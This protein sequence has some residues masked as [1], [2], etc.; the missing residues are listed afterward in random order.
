MKMGMRWRTLYRLLVVLMIG[1]VW[2]THGQSVWAQPSGPRLPLCNEPRIKIVFTEVAQWGL[3]LLP[4]VPGA[5][6]TQLPIMIEA[7]QPITPF[8]PGNVEQLLISP[9]GRA[10]GVEFQVLALVSDHL[11]YLI[12]PATATLIP[13]IGGEQVIWLSWEPTDDGWKSSPNGMYVN[14]IVAMLESTDTVVFYQVQVNRSYS[15]GSITTNTPILLGRQNNTDLLKGMSVGVYPTEPNLRGIFIY[16]TNL[17]GWALWVYNKPIPGS[18]PLNNPF[19]PPQAR[20]LIASP[21]GKY[22]ALYENNS[23]YLL[24]IGVGKGQLKTRIDA[25][26]PDPFVWYRDIMRG[27]SL[28]LF[29]QFG[30]PML[31]IVDST[32]AT[33]ECK[34]SIPPNL[35]MGDVGFYP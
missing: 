2:Q 25:A 14:L 23:L 16:Q 18:Q 7:G 28:L 32:G 5:Q 17:P 24:T 3:R 15:S 11:I 1:V 26:D 34:V 12:N 33:S 29:L 22:V 30:E 10:N 19:T 35:K 4:I 6:Q 13:V 20:N 8:Y 27:R 9:T 21:N 31:L